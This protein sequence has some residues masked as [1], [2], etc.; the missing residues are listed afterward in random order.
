ME[1]RKDRLYYGPPGLRPKQFMDTQSAKNPTDWFPGSRVHFVHQGRTAIGIACR[2]LGLKSGDEVL[3]PSYNCGAEID[4]LIK[5]GATVVLYRIDRSLRIDLEDLRRKI[6]VKTRVVYLIHYFGFP[7]PA[8]RI[9]QICEEK[10]LFLIEDCA[11]ALFSRHRG[12]MLG[13]TGDISIFSITKTLP[14]PDGGVLVINNPALGGESLTLRNI[15]CK[16]MIGPL[17]HLQKAGLLRWLSERPDLYS[18]IWPLYRKLRALKNTVLK[19]DSHNDSK[20]TWPEIPKE[21]YFTESSNNR[22]ISPLTWFLLKTFDLPSMIE[23]R[24]KNFT[25]YLD[26]LSPHH[27]IVPLFDELPEGICPLSFPVIVENRD[28]LWSSLREQS[29]YAIRWWWGY[30]R[31][32]PWAEYPDACY[33]KNNVLTLPLH[34]DLAE[35]HIAFIS[36]HTI[37]LV[38]NV[39]SPNVEA[40]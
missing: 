1:N 16:R 22:K 39:I 28:N 29:V 20:Q 36:D 15:T 8:A 14:V 31:H 5:S 32:L 37:N 21:Y 35:D 3:A 6:T 4:P 27:S 38:K 17:L 13:S 30:H 26:L 33:L 9:K 11:L 24:R 10:G 2:L 7:Q 19:I 25:R 18:H 23:K 40:R 34:E 12:V